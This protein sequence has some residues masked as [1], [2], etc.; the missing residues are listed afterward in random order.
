MI[1]QIN[2][3]ERVNGTEREWQL[4]RLRACRRKGKEIR[5]WRPY[6]FYSSL[7]GCYRA[8]AEREVRLAP[9]I[10][11]AQD[12][13]FKLADLFADHLDIRIGVTKPD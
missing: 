9:D 8:L 1:I 12:R 13:I 4:Q 7:G 2:D 10:K 5:E 6:Q 3:T 11:K